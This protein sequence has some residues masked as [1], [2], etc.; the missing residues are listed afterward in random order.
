MSLGD[1]VKRRRLFLRAFRRLAQGRLARAKNAV[2]TIRWYAPGRLVAKRACKLLWNLISTL[3]LCNVNEPC[4]MAASRADT[5]TH[6]E[7][8]A[9]NEAPLVGGN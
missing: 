4:G 7:S 1:N 5:S 3:L 2:A 6:F 9:L 8:P